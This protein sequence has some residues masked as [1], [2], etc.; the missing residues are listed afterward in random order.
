[1]QQKHI[2]KLSLHCWLQTNAASLPVYK[3]CR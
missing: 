1:M 3:F 2:G